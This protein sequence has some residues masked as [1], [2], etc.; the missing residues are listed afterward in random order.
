MGEYPL[1]NS[2]LLNCFVV[3]SA[4]DSTPHY[5][6]TSR[7]DGNEERWSPE[8]TQRLRR[9]GQD[10]WHQERRENLASSVHQ[11]SVG[12]PQGE[13]SAG[14]PEQAVVHSQRHHGAHLRDREDQVFQHV[15]VPEGPPHQPRQIKEATDQSD[16]ANYSD[17]NF[18]ILI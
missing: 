13:G 1:T 8:G 7:R 3:Q 9:A 6:T 15:Q 18:S 12:L 4:L 5:T 2:L 14:S 11:A 17:F 16:I 10:N